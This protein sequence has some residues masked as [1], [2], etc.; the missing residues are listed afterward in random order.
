MALYFASQALL[1]QALA[2]ILASEAATA[3][4]GC[5]TSSILPRRSCR[6]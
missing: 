6:L 1:A 4:I 5:P 3:K 2:V